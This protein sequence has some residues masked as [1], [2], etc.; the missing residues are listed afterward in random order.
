MP[1]CNF[2]EKTFASTSSLNAHQKKTRYCLDIQKAKGLETKET[3]Y[4][5]SKCKHNFTIKEKYNNHVSNCTF[6]DIDALNLIIKNEKKNNDVLQKEND[7]Y[8]FE[9]E[10]LKRE[11]NSIIELLKQENKDLKSELALERT[12]SSNLLSRQT[13]LLA[14]KKS[15]TTINNTNN[16]NNGKIIL[17]ASFN[18]EEM[19][20]KGFKNFTMDDSKTPKAMALFVKKEVLTDKKGVLLYVC[21]DKNRHN[22]RYRNPEGE[23]ISDP[24]A[25]N[26][27]EQIRLF[28]KDEL[29]SRCMEVVNYRE[30]EVDDPLDKMA[31]A[32][33][34]CYDQKN[35]RLGPK[36]IDHLAEQTY[37]KRLQKKLN[38]LKREAGEIIQNEENEENEE[39]EGPEEIKQQ[40][41]EKY[42]V[43]RLSIQSHPPR[44]SVLE[45]ER[46]KNLQIEERL[47]KQRV[48]IA[49][50]RRKKDLEKME[51]NKYL[52]EIWSSVEKENN[53]SNT[54]D[55]DEESDYDIDDTD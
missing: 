30:S 35:K 48:E 44:I 41:V 6:N 45:K 28:A 5:C 39:H 1:T 19:I 22:F 18:A 4:E 16:T 53:D 15:V 49:E 8:K 26:L 33:N 47:E 23:E 29:H 52:E 54:N 50:I 37:V 9:V 51:H 34:A 40:S 7:A 46:L 12:R 38:Q 3:I 36:F 24:N 2:C 10:V 11:N 17:T 42:V 25:T 32:T 20:K 13:E 43:P 55:V 14:H 21:T 27:I 31:E